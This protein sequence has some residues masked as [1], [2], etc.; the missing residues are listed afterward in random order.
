MKKP[1]DVWTRK[2]VAAAIQSGTLEERVERLRKIGLIDEKNQLTERYQNWG[3]GET[4]TLE[5]APT[6]EA[7]PDG[8]S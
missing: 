4:R 2:A 8:A 5:E 3:M 1:N 7:K 6:S